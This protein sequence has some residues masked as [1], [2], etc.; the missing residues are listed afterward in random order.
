MH[1]KMHTYYVK[2]RKNRKEITNSINELLHANYEHV[3][4]KSQF[5][6]N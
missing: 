3:A 6:D 4:P 5:F 2:K 1:Y